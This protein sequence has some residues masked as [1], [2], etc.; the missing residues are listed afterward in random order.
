MAA[1]QNRSLIKPPDRL[2]TATEDEVAGLYGVTNKILR[3]WRA[4]RR[5]PAFVK[6]SRKRNIVIAREP[7][8]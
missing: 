1:R 8:Q 6:E 2:G 5:G 4:E 3:N 7:A